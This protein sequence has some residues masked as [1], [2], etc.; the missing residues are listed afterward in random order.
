[1]LM[2]SRDKS[3]SK[4]NSLAGLDGRHGAAAEPGSTDL[5]VG[6]RRRDRTDEVGTG[7]NHLGQALC[8]QQADL[9]YFQGVQFDSRIV[10]A[11][12]FIVAVASLHR[13]TFA[14]HQGLFVELGLLEL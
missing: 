1:M 12:P 14:D 13:A 2:L 4:S 10:V 6:D 9:C 3:R 8:T 5:D 11:N 7:G